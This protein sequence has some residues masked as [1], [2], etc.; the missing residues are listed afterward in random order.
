MVFIGLYRAI[1]DYAPQADNEIAIREGDLVCV[2]EKGDDDWWKAKKKAQSDTDDEP[3]GLIPGNYVEEATPIGKAN[4][5]YEYT[6][7]TDEELSFNDG[8][9][10]DVYDMSDKDWTLVGLKG[11]YGFVPAIYIEIEEAPP[12]MPSRPRPAAEPTGSAEA[13][14]QRAL[15][16]PPS[17]SSRDSSDQSPAAALAGIIQSRSNAVK[18]GSSNRRVPSIPG[19]ALPP[20]KQVQF[21]PEE[22]EEEAPAPKLPRRPTNEEISPAASR[23]KRVSIREPEPEAE[24]TGVVESPPYNRVVSAYYDEDKAHISPG[25]FHLYNIFEMIEVMG[26]NRKTPVTLGINIAKGVISISSEDSREAKEWSSDKL[27]HYSLEGKHVF[28]ELVRPSKSIDFHAGAKDTAQEIVSALAELSSAARV[29]GLHDFFAAGSQKIGKILYDFQAGGDDEVS[30]YVGDEVTIL[31]DAKNDDWWF[32]RRMDNG[33]EGVVP[34]SYVKVTE[35]NTNGRKAARDGGSESFVERNRREEERLARQASK[36]SKTE[37]GPGLTLPERGSSLSQDGSTRRS[38]R[39]K[40]DG[41]SSKKSSEYAAF[42]ETPTN[43]KQCLI[44]VE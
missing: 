42:Y 41:G 39:Q 12:P 2:K 13:V 33:K 1:Y 25:G 40:K 9:V 20:R 11:E 21:T 29:E 8:T 4:A 22:S 27:T 18:A 23:S 31:D 10:L 32:V 24:P 38:Q 35:V 5:M 28:M 37:I 6:R 3:E 15:R 30:V 36:A 26:K 17:P 14:T 43:T 19:V 16:A 34:S 44:L 7:Q